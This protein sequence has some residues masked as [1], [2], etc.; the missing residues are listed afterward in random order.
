MIIKS[1]S[2]INFSL[3]INSKSNSGFHEIQSL[4]S[5]IDL[6]DIIKIKKIK[7][8]KDKVVFNG[9]FSKLVNKR[10]NSVNKILKQLRQAKLITNYYSVI[11]TK[12]IPV[13]GGLGGGTSNAAF[14]LK[15]LIKSKIKENL[16]N[17]IES[18]IG[19]DFKLFFKK[20]GFLNDLS[21][22]IELKKRQIFYLV[23]VQ[24]KVKCST[25]EIY[26]KVKKFSKKK[27]FDKSL[28]KSKSRF[29]EYL[30][31]SRNDL[32]SIVENKYPIIRKL[33][34]DIKNEK[35]CYFS[36]MTGSGSVCYGLFKD[37]IVAK[38]ALKKLSYKYPRFWFSFAKTV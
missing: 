9:P 13:F 32:Q 35:G 22:I 3:K 10:N 31:K 6:A 24:P 27:K 37:Q 30:V 34:I 29:L 15:H 8:N 11:V 17:K 23:L 1:Y 21:T 33:L 7:K 36:R 19:S 25:K 14:I 28:T 16:L 5:W 20:N 26:S 2:K 38:K 4:Y 12:N 18:L